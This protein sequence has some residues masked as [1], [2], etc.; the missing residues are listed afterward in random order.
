M[1]PQ[2]TTNAAI[3]CAVIHSSQFENERKN[4]EL[5][6]SLQDGTVSATRP[7]LNVVDWEGPCDPA[8][9]LNWTFGR[10]SIT[11]ALVSSMTLLR[12]AILLI[13]CLQLVLEAM[14]IPHSSLSS[15]IFAPGIASVMEEFHSTSKELA[16]FIVS[17]YVI[18][19]AF[20]PLII[21]PLSEIYG[22]TLLYYICNSLFTVFTIACAVAPN[23]SALVTFRLLAGL[24][25]GYPLAAAAGTAADI[26]T[27]EKRGKVVAALGFGPLLGPIIGPVGEY[28]KKDDI[29]Q[30]L[31]DNYSGGLFDG[32]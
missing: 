32:C 28:L 13:S 7:N 3:S 21:A 9:P 8:N 2:A 19:Y 10:K 6:L 26:I 12:Y 11:V 25:A 18:G 23:L 30:Y 4:V 29:L 17:V 14:L 27:Y 20:G 5:L 16:S 24:S 1:K 22:R 31:T 15:S